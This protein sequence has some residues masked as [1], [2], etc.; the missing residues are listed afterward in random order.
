MGI[1]N[2]DYSTLTVTSAA[3]VVATACTPVM[4]TTAKGAIIT[5]ENDQIRY[6]SDG[7]APTATEGHLL[8]AGDILTYDSWTVPNANWRS[9]LKALQ[10]IEVTNDAKLKISWYD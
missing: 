10:V 4:P 8:S 1:N 6:R 3:Q 5:V 9:A 7:T 2:V